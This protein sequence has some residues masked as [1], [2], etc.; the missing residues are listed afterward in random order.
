MY[1]RKA[2]SHKAARLHFSHVANRIHPLNAH[3]AHSFPMRGGF[4]L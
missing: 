2:M 4:R 3:M 1:K